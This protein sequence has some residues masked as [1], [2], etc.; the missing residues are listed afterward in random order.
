M[1]KEIDESKGS[2]NAETVMKD[3]LRKLVGMQKE[4]SMV[5]KGEE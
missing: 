1:E 5:V 4:A 3:A 2:K